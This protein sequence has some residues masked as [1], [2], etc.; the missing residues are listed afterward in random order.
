MRR[1]QF[2]TLARFGHCI[3]NS[4]A[5]ASCA[6]LVVHFIVTSETCTASSKKHFHSLTHSLLISLFILL[7]P[8]AIS[9][10]SKHTIRATLLHIY[11]SHS[12]QFL[13]GSNSYGFSSF[14]EEFLWCNH[15]DR[16]RIKTGTKTVEMCTSK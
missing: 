12:H 7:L 9:N 15:S 8:K 11:R 16:Q 2:C 4:T 13:C 1:T 14:F 10:E 6:Q 5:I 3:N